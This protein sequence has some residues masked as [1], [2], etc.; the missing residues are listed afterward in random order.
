MNF[1]RHSMSGKDLSIRL[2]DLNNSR[3]LF[4]FYHKTANRMV[5]ICF[6][7]LTLGRKHY[8][9]SV[10]RQFILDLLRLNRLHG[11]M[12]VIKYLKASV[13][14]VQRRVGGC[15]LNSLRALEPDL[16]LPSL[17]DGLPPII[18]KRDRQAIAHLGDPGI[19]RY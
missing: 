11:S 13:I 3:E 1:N 15:P 12:F 16:P 2:L 17:I 14:A 9:L 5:S 4:S 18:S 10:F 6:A 7:R 19:V 8:R